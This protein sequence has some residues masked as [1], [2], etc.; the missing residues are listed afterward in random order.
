[1]LKAD[2]KWL[3]RCFLT[4]SL[5]S[6]ALSTS[7]LRE[8]M[9]AIAATEIVDFERF[10]YGMHSLR[11]GREAELRGANVRPEL[12]NDITS[13]TTIG[14]RAPYSRAERLELVKANRLAD[15]VVVKP[16][17]TAVRFES[18]RSAARADVFLSP[19]GNVLK[20]SEARDRCSVERPDKRAR[21]SG[22]LAR[23]FFQSK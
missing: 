10:D 19:A 23:D 20:P 21:T 7:Q 12:I 13:H 18:D 17:E 16:M 3:R 22:P 2:Q 4:G 6:D 1:M 14:G 15:G 11:I 9:R 5:Y 8:T